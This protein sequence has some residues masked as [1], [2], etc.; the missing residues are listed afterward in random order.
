MNDTARELQVL[1]LHKTEGRVGNILTDFNGT[2]TNEW[3][4]DVE[5]YRCLYC[6][7]VKEGLEA[8][9]Q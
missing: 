1:I 5:N 3:M 6:T 9:L 2:V 7:R 4:N 8:I